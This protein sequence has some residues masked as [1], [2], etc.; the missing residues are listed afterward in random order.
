MHGIPQLI[1]YRRR[2]LLES[3][4]IRRTDVG[5]EIEQVS[6][7]EQYR[8]CFCVEQNRPELRSIEQYIRTM[9]HDGNEVITME[10]QFEN[11]QEAKLAEEND[12]ND[13]SQKRIDRIAEKAA[14][15]PTKVQQHFDKENSN[16]FT[17]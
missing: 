17:K 5:K 1:V 2:P 7:N 10:K 13:S 11:P 9:K 15:K 3:L 6:E 4:R 12:T 14:E 8:P 16:L